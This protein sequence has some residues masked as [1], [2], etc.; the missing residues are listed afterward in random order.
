M[1]IPI[2]KGFLLTQGPTESHKNFGERFDILLGRWEE[3]AASL[4]LKELVLLDLRASFSS[5]A[6][7]C[8]SPGRKRDSVKRTCWQ[9][10]KRVHDSE[11][12]ARKPLEES[13]PVVPS[14]SGTHSSA[15]S[16]IIVV[17]GGQTLGVTLLT[18]QE[19]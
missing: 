18:V 15:A 19:V 6:T 11:F 5:A 14:K 3:A 8:K 4:D 1:S 16:R 7:E 13:N 2:V 17:E 10:R 12:E 9:I